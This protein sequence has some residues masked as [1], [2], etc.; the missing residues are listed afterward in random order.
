MPPFSPPPHRWENTCC[1]L[2]AECRP[3]GAR[4]PR[5]PATSSS[6]P[7][8]CRTGWRE[9]EQM[10]VRPE[11]PSP[12]TV[13]DQSPGGAPVPSMH[14]TAV[15]QMIHALLLSLPLW[16]RLTV[17]CMLW[18]NEAHEHA[19]PV[20]AGCSSVPIS[21]PESSRPPCRGTAVPDLRPGKYC[22]HPLTSVPD[23][24]RIRKIVPACRCP[25]DCWPSS[26]Q[27]EQSP[28]RGQGAA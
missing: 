9:S 22:T 12:A 16:S 28:S 20:Q 23:F 14:R 1:A 7:F 5:S 19:Q 3:Q 25:I 27:G 26:L 21:R 17:Q 2:K 18:W 11:L 6:A 24:R 13:F 8:R 10:T 4:G 15:R